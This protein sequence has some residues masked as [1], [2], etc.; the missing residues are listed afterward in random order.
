MSTNS[1]S[2][3]I[4]RFAPSP[5]GL[6]H[7]GNV[8][9][10]LMNFL[11]ARSV[12]GKF[13]L[14]IDDTDKERS[15]RELEEAIKEDLVWLGIN[16]DET[17]RQS[18]RIL[19]YEEAKERLIKS[20]RLYPC[21]ETEEELA[22][23]KKLLLSKNLPPIYDRKSLRL[24]VEQKAELE[25]GGLKPHW[26]FLLDDDMVM[27]DDKI[28]GR[29]NFKGRSV[30]DPILIRSDGTMTYTIASIVD[31]VDCGI[32]DIIRGEDHLS[33]SAVH[34]Q[35]FKA[36]GAAKIPDFAHLPLLVGKDKEISKRI[37]GFD[38]RGLRE[39]GI[40]A[41]AINNMLGKLG[42]NDS[43][44][45]KL[46]LDELATEFNFAKFGKAAI[47]YDPQ[48]L[49]RINAKLVR[50][51]PYESI[52]LHPGARGVVSKDFWLAV[53]KNL[54]KVREIEDWLKICEERV[55]PKIINSQLT[56]QAAA[57]FPENKLDDETF[58]S[59]IKD[60]ELKTGVKGRDLFLP[61]RLALTG[62]ERG[63]ELKL[64]LPILGRDKVI[65]RLRGEKA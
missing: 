16:W 51:L 61:I 55:D 35:I 49:E 20:G 39:D 38:I 43:P 37:G 12:F 10:A 62:L 53:R 30:S 21:Y 60:V 3:I 4:V 31:D 52:Q 65:A 45:P 15:S 23:Q 7:V 42:T 29:I 5:T 50:E 44:G 41:M 54:S 25:A 8:R 63:P 1:A 28:K 27:W 19:R 18:E 40:E 36:L 58:E 32:T 17:F 14:R 56:L 2:Q 46:T 33:N 48:E 11:Y 59:W 24:T 34:I 26:R 47:T 64:L 13:I 9:T 22:I 57:L 6:L